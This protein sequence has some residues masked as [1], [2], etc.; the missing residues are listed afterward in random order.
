MD[1]SFWGTGCLTFKNG[2]VKCGANTI[3]VTNALLT[4]SSHGP[5]HCALTD[6]MSVMCWGAGSI[7]AG[8]LINDVQP[9]NPIEVL[10]LRE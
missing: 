1:Y 5:I 2:S 3:G 9:A 4:Q 6:K 7:D 8:T 10:N